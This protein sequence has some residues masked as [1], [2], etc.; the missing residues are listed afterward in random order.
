[1]E[2]SNKRN[3]KGL[4]MREIT[5]EELL[6]AGAHFGHQVTRSNP[7]ARDFI[8]EARDGIHII[9]LSKT[10]QGLDEAAQFIKTLAQNPQA[11]L[12]VVGTKRQAKE[13]VGEE[14]ARVKKDLEN[15]RIFSIQNRWIGGLF[16]NFSEIEK[17]FKKLK[18]FDEKLSNPELSAGYTKKEIEG[19]KKEKQKLEG[20]YGGVVDMKGLPSAIFIIDSH[21]ENLAAREAIAS[22]VTTVAIVDTNSDPEPINYPIPANDDAAGSIKLIV[23]HIMDAW[24]EGSKISLKS[25]VESSKS[26]TESSVEN[27]KTATTSKKEAGSKNQESVKTSKLSSKPKKSTK[28][29]ES[30]K[31]KEA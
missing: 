22:G 10:K 6:E 1:M 17:N 9:D 2:G 18:D 25:K 4:N 11:T 30:S 27:K 7:K 15:P 26:E 16:T 5:L 31:V 14:V 21:M 19:W 20:F 3:K 12:L 13:I 24:I 28:N 8:F 29:K 23:S